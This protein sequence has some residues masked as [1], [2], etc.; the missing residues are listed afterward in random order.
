[1]KTTQK[2][3]QIETYKCDATDVDMVSFSFEESDKMIGGILQLNSSYCGIADGFHGLAELHLS[4]EV[5]EKILRFLLNKYPKTRENE[6]I[7]H[8]L[9][10]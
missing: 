9:S 5:T 3:I 2:T 4:R 8:C 10:K 1:M 7:Q 6:L